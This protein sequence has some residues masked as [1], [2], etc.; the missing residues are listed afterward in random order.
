MLTL[1][2]PPS[3]RAPRSGARL[4]VANEVRDNLRVAWVDDADPTKGFR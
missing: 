2:T 1:A 4:G 3:H